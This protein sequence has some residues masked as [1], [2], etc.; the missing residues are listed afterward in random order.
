MER[1]TPSQDLVITKDDQSEPNV[2]SGGSAQG[3][4]GASESDQQRALSHRHL[5]PR[6]P[7]SGGGESILFWI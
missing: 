2:S 5:H 3:W 1:L 6:R 4:R 7:R